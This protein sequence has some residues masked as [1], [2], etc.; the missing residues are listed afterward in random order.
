MEGTIMQCP[1]CQFENRERAKFCKECGHYFELICPK[2]SIKI[3][4]DN[5]FCHE[6][7]SILA[8][9]LEPH[10][11]IIKTESQTFTPPAK[12]PLNKFAPNSLYKK[13]IKVY[14]K[15]DIIFEEGSFGNEMFIIRT[16]KI[17][18]YTIKEGREIVLRTSEKGEIFG[19]MALVDD[20]PRS[21]TAI[22]EENNTQLIVV[23]HSKFLY[24]V[25]QQPPFALTI[26]H[27]L[28]ERLRISEPELLNI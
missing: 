25:N 17:R 20:T 13:F 28:C 4:D 27:V 6:C 5:K 16:G 23:D 15:S 19:E 1:K 22:A 7:G 26:M 3:I 24:M 9:T 21:G 11:E 2:C 8:S 12:K 14:N 18:I 10:V